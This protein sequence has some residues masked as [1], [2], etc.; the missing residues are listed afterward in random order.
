MFKDQTDHTKS[1]DTFRGFDNQGYPQFYT[2]TQHLLISRFDEY[3]LHYL[4]DHLPQIAMNPQG[5]G[6][7]RAREF[8]DLYIQCRLDAQHEYDLNTALSP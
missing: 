2:E 1:W 8:Q 4:S 7:D 5:D 6:L 3:F